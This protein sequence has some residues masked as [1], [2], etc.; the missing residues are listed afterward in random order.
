MAMSKANWWQM[1]LDLFWKPK[2]KPTDILA[3]ERANGFDFA[4]FEWRY[5]N[6]SATGSKPTVKMSKAVINDSGTIVDLFYD[7][8]EG[9][10]LGN[11]D[12]CSAGVVMGIQ[13]PDGHYYGGRFDDIGF[14]MIARPMQHVW[15]QAAENYDGVWREPAKGAKV[16]FFL[17]SWDGNKYSHGAQRSTAGFDVWKTSVEMRKE[18]Q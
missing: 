1:I 12:G 7:K 4:K 14:S 10:F 6:W 5:G 17:V 18:Q 15:D 8:T 13:A 2:Q 9:V 16:C 11:G 3:V